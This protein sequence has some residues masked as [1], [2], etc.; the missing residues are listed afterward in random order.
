M[1]TVTAMIS[2]EALRARIAEMAAAMAPRL[3]DGVLAVA[4]CKGAFIFAA[5][6][7]RALS[8]CGVRLQVD[9]MI[10]SSYGTGQASSGSVNLRLEVQEPI[11][12]R[13]IL[14]IDDILDSGHTLEAAIAHLHSRGAAE[15]LTAVLLDKPER[16]QREVKAD[17]TGFVIPNRFV[18]GFGIDHAE[19][20][21]E[22]P[23]VGWVP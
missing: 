19:Q 20:F 17:F 15:I 14:L 18:V 1:N 11:Q 23:Y 12:D 16:R 10:V 3:R 5:D 2:E 21:R 7:L 6:L 8:R 22:L 4:L 9:F 13:Q